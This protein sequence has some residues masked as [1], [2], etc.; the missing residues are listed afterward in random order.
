MKNVVR[1]DA[2]KTKSAYNISL[3]ASQFIPMQKSRLEIRMKQS[4]R[5]FQ[6]LNED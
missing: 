5:N 6:N 1:C 3:K 2:K 4:N